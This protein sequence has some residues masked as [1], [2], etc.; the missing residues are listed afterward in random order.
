[1]WTEHRKPRRPAR[2]GSAGAGQPVTD[3]ELRDLKVR[4]RL[5]KPPSCL[6]SWVP[7][8]S[9]SRDR[10]TGVARGAFYRPGARSWESVPVQSRRDGRGPGRAV[11]AR[12]RGRA[13]GRRSLS[14][15]VGVEGPRLQEAIAAGRVI[16]VRGGQRVPEVLPDLV[17]HPGAPPAS[18]DEVQRPDLRPSPNRDNVG[19]KLRRGGGRRA[20]GGRSKVVLAGVRLVLDRD[21]RLL[22]RRRR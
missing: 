3:G 8:D 5:V 1:M 15:Q 6:V 10:G 22:S 4:P 19:V 16:G 14:V 20:R 2:S 18:P 9:S 13:R 17:V 7:D 11:R 12:L 21:V